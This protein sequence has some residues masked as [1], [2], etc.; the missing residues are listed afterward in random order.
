MFSVIFFLARNGILLKLS[1]YFFSYLL[2]IILP[3]NIQSKSLFPYL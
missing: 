3:F 1:E 2:Y